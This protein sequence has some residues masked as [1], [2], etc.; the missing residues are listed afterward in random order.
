MPGATTCSATANRIALL[1]WDTVSTGPRK[2]D[3]VPTLQA[4]RFGLLGTERD[5]FVTAYDQDIRVWD[6]YPILRELRDISTFIAHCVTPRQPAARQELAIRFRSLLIGD[7]R[8]GSL[9][10]I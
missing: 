5:A 2:I 1:D 3:M 8:D 4:T 6:G 9:S 10:D 7:S